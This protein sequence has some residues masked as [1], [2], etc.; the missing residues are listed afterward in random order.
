MSTESKEL[1]TL[2]SKGNWVTSLWKPKSLWGQHAADSRFK[3]AIRPSGF[4]HSCLLPRMPRTWQGFN[5]T[6]WPWARAPLS[7]PR[8]SLSSLVLGHWFLPLLPLPLKW[9]WARWPAWSVPWMRSLYVVVQSFIQ[10][11]CQGGEWELKSQEEEFCFSFWN[12]LSPNWN[13]ILKF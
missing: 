2:P 11:V 9:L 8:A 5:V 3:L 12:S 6:S 10:E 4:L 7:S 1:L 13:K